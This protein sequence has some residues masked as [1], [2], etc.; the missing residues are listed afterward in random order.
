MYYIGI[1]PGK[2]GA[3]AI[4]REDEVIFTS[5]FDEI[6]YRD[7]LMRILGFE[8]KCCVEKVASMPKQGVASTFSFGKNAGF[9]ERLLVAYSIPYQLVPP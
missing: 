6:C 5:A 8:A 4:M 1:D 7:A 3:L 9:I 2:E